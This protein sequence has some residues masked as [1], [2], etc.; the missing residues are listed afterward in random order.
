[1]TSFRAR[2]ELSDLLK[3][4]EHCTA[5]EAALASIGRAVGQQV[6]IRTRDQDFALFTVRAATESNV[7]RVSSSGLARLGAKQAIDA[8]VESDAL[9]PAFADR[10]DDEV[11]AA[12]EM[13]ERF[14]E[15]EGDELIVIAPHGGAIEKGTD[16]QAALMA[17]ELGVCSWICKGWKP[18]GGAFA[19]WHI[20]STDTHEASFPKLGALGP[21]RFRHAVAFHGWSGGEIIIGGGASSRLKRAVAMAVRFVV[22]S[23]KIPVRVA[24]ASDHYGG[25][26]PRNLVNR[27]TRTGTL[28][29]QLEQP[30]EAR[31]N[32]AEPIAEAV[33]WVYRN[34]LAVEEAWRRRFLK[35]SSD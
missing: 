35:R 29:L 11:E 14:T 33:T 5:S 6:R 17:R 25:D 18:G 9:D 21:R 8:E 2:I 16:R 4:G 34:L 19:R 10:S 15:R 1:M 31:E 22:R 23:S 13:V 20:T 32:N 30:R 28:G 3:S 26:D 24:S 27:L 12:G 7:V